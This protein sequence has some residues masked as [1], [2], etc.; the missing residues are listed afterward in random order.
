MMIDFC[1]NSTLF[2]T[3]IDGFEPCTDILF[4][5][6]IDIGHRVDN[7]ITWMTY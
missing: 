1:V 2:C 6:N 3:A 7:I 4:E 5:T